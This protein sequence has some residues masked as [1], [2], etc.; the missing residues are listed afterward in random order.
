MGKP[1]RRRSS[2]RRIGRP[3]YSAAQI[4]TVDSGH[5]TRHARVPP[6]L[7]TQALVRFDRKT[8]AFFLLL[9]TLFALGAAFKVHGS[10]I[11]IWHYRLGPAYRSDDSGVL[12]G[13]P[14]GIRID[15]WNIFTPAILSQATLHPSFPVVNA[16]W[17]Q[18]E[19]PLVFKFPARHWSMILRPQFWGFFVLDVE[20]AFAFY[21]DIRAVLL[22]GGTFLLLMVLTENHFWISV[23][24]AAWFLFSGFIQ[25]WYS[26][27]LLPEMIGFT[28]LLVVAAHY[29][30]LSP[31]RWV[32]AVSGLACL[33]CAF[34]FALGL[35]PPYQVPLFYIGVIVSAAS[36]GPRLRRAEVR[37][38]LALRVAS[39]SL[40]LIGLAV[41]LA[42]F[43]R[44]AREGV[45]LMRATV[46]P[47]SRLVSGGDLKLAQ[48]FGGFFGFFMTEQRFPQAFYGGNICESS[49][50]VLLF[51]I[52]AI[53]VI[54]RWW[55][56][57]PVTAIEWVL[58]VYIVVFLSWIIVGWPHWLAAASAFGLTQ[59][60]RAQ[61]A[62]GVG[63]ILFCCIF[64][65]KS[66]VDLP[67]GFAR[68]VSVAGCVMAALLAYALYFN[69]VTSGF[70][71]AGEVALVVLVG[72][73]AGYLLLA[74]QRLPFAICVL[75]PQVW[76]YALVN[77]VAV[78]LGPV[79]NAR[80]FQQVSQLVAKDPE[81]RWAA[82]L[83]IEAATFL[84]MAGAKVFNGIN[85]IPPMND[86]R[87][88]DP[89]GLAKSTYNRYGYIVLVPQQGS[90]VTFKYVQSDLYMMAVDPKNDLWRRLG[91]RYIVLSSPSTDPEFIAKMEPIQTVPG[92]WIYKL[93][94]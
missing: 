73:A 43:Y 55:H 39:A 3:P 11:G 60:A 21:W 54:W 74:R 65:A 89:E 69:R 1:R 22:L 2:S 71:T 20:R 79:F 48:V 83:D 13:T 94:S 15:E 44:D 78:G 82:Y 85:I 25:W 37:S 75:A 50:F 80:L 42:L 16:R 68:N 49:S 40:A 77:P 12:F 76:S 87:T 33:V 17:G 7:L 4:A 41:L 9:L 53:V 59:P 66:R 5:R 29:L 47:G 63:N 34:N 86:F 64:L 36:L 56:R 38:N 26:N 45:N 61:L 93:R 91:I 52:P 51:P 67:R 70:A 90:T 32:I 84:K 92:L 6:A 8:A 10:S 24:G 62:L 31:R 46:Y 19:V 30:V 27:Q 88:I 57:Q 23:V 58:L 35:Y 81:A 18:G 28:G 72:G 14:K